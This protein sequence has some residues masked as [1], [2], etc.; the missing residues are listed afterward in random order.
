MAEAESTATTTVV[1]YRDKSP[2]EKMI[3]LVREAAPRFEAIYVI[4]GNPDIFQAYVDA[5]FTLANTWKRLYYNPNSQRAYVQQLLADESNLRRYLFVFDEAPFTVIRSPAFESMIMNHT[6]SAIVHLR[7]PVDLVPDACRA[8]NAVWSLNE[9]NA[10][11][12]N[13]HFWAADHY[14]C[15]LHTSFTY[16]SLEAMKKLYRRHYY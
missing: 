12:L 6:A 8:V 4:T 7:R 3:E 1:I 10:W 16:T 14:R 13:D 5:G 15:C 2:T 11:V 9:E